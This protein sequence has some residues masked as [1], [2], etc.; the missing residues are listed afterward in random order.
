MDAGR[1]FAVS[2]AVDVTGED[3]SC[4]AKLGEGG[5][6]GSSPASQGSKMADLPFHLAVDDVTQW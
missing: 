3:E 2:R 5:I 1:S 4:L 6:Q